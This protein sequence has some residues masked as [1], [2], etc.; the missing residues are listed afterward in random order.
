M[1]HSLASKYQDNDRAAP[2][3]PR[4]AIRPSFLARKESQDQNSNSKLQA[5]SAC[6]C[7]GGCPRCAQSTAVQTSL[8]IS[9]PGDQY[10]READR[11]AEQVMRM[12]EPESPRAPD[13]MDHVSTS[14]VQRK[15]SACAEQAT[16]D[17]P[18]EELQ[19]QALA[20]TDEA[21]HAGDDVAARVNALQSGGEP[22]SKQTREFFEP[23]FGQD[24]GDV[25]VHAG[26]MAA[27]SARAVS[28]R[29]YTIG[30]D[31]VFG[32]REYS[33]QTHDGRRL[34]AHELTHVVQ[35]RGDR[36]TIQRQSAPEPA[37]PAA[38]PKPKA[39]PCTETEQEVITKLQFGPLPLIL[40]EVDQFIN[41]SQSQDP[42]QRGKPASVA[43]AIAR[44]FHVTGDAAKPVIAI[45][46]RRLAAVV[47][48][49][50]HAMN[51]RCAADPTFRDCQ[52]TDAFV[53][54]GQAGVK[55]LTLCPSL[56]A[57]DEHARVPSLIRELVRFWNNDV[58]D[59]RSTSQRGYTDLS[60]EEALHNA[61]SYGQLAAEI[62]D[63]YRSR[64]AASQHIPEPTATAPKVGAPSDVYA[65]C[66]ATKTAALTSAIRKA[67]EVNLNALKVMSD[68]DQI[69]AHGAALARYGLPSPVRPKEAAD[70]YR[71][72]Y[73]SANNLFKK[74]VSITCEKP[75]SPYCNA[76]TASY[77][78]SFHVCPSRH[79]LFA[80]DAGLSAE[81]LRAFYRTYAKGEEFAAEM[82]TGAV[83]D[84]A[85]EMLALS[86]RDEKITAEPDQPA[87]SRE[88][89][90]EEGFLL[91][92]GAGFGTSCGE[93]REQDRFDKRYWV[94]VPGTNLTTLTA[95]VEPWLAFSKLVE[96]L[97]EDVTK[98][99]EQRR[100]SFDCFEGVIVPRIYSYWRTMNR[101]AFNLKFSPLELGYRGNTHLG[102]KEHFLALKPGDPP[103]T[104]VQAANTA[105]TG[106]DAQRKARVN[107]T[108]AELLRGAP[109]GSQVIW[110]NQ[111]A[112]NKCAK[113]KNLSFC[114]FQN[115]NTTKL[116][117]SDKFGPH[118]FGTVLSES[119]IT[120]RMAR[121]VL[122]A[123]K[124]ASDP[125][126]TA[127]EVK[128]Y[129]KKNIY[130]ST[131]RHPDW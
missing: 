31:V 129:I 8:K 118:P 47:E 48:S 46:K 66:D 33:P 54:D 28:A 102:Y 32:S 84:L 123:G 90:L 80:D 95:K 49:E 51:I 124:Q 116:V 53:A 58:V 75:D 6:A 71:L 120:D 45:V 16:P 108:W 18:E 106:G 17:F 12:R 87:I 64:V 111:D 130:I 82:L 131:I 7:G 89:A 78:G 112:I 50:V 63:A 4:T 110:T 3:G 99:T 62:Y 126:A 57:L 60:T 59:R 56:F 85:R 41:S 36:R 25:R 94:H 91:L 117:G 104:Y 77:D 44:N 105:G 24:F 98:P 5:E 14:G 10:E 88:M 96:F 30:R 69:K 119:E 101:S 21:G 121:A 125:K 29:A 2:W 100:W 76:G 11:V 9:T 55:M 109:P 93:E 52:L 128:A 42:A 127:A 92:E 34:L 40:S 115:E 67:E 37:A 43:D 86:T 122:D 81:L 23:R 68:R 73:E 70:P 20:E 22:L 61:S 35:Q 65:G 13:L 19:R 79:N 15:C 107:K 26:A 83:Q 72:G 27:D 113:D 1:T 103:Q 97:K 114:D 38:P 39:A 74:S